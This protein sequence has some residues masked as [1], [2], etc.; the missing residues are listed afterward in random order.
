ME[1]CIKKRRSYHE[2]QSYNQMCIK[3]LYKI[4]EPDVAIDKLAIVQE[5]APVLVR[6][7]EL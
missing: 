2:E 5:V 3:F 1:T 4:D 6:Q 7:K